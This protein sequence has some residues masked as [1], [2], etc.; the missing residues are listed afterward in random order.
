[1]KP[2]KSFV[3]D[4]ENLTLSYRNGSRV[5]NVYE[6]FDLKIQ[7]SEKVAL[8]GE[9]G[10]GKSTLARF[11]CG[12]LPKTA[13]IRDGRYLLEER[14][15]YAEH[16]FFHVNSVRGS[17]IAFI[18]QDAAESLNPVR[19]ILEQFTEL[20]LYHRICTKSEVETIAVKKLESLRIADIPR[21]LHAYPFELSGGMCQRVC[22]AMCL[23][24]NPVLLI[25][26]E[27]TSALDIRSTLRVLENISDLKNVAVLTITH[28]ISVAAKV[29]DRIIVLERGRISEEGTVSEILEYPKEAYTRELVAA[30]RN[31][32][33]LKALSEAK[34]TPI[35]SVQSVRKKYGGEEVLKD[36]SFEMYEEEV[37]GIIGESGCGKSTLCRC[38]MGL[39]DQVE[40][41]ILY[42]NK[43]LLEMKRKERRKLSTEIQMIFQNSRA[44]LNPGKSVRNL[45]MEPLKYNRLYDERERRR[46]AEE[47]LDAVEIPVKDREARPSELSTGQC[48]RVS[49]ARALSVNPKILVADEA[50]SALDVMIQYQVLELL[51]T[52][53]KDFH[54]TVLMI[55]H[56]IRLLRNY[57]DRI[58]IMQEGRFLEILLW[59]SGEG[60]K[61]E[62]TKFL[63]EVADHLTF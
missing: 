22:I 37:F 18:F 61:E 11:L 28:D 12:L 34:E 9:S 48:Q 60:A 5:T 26:D 54:L 44:V 29:A 50:V 58:G 7:T 2:S 33:M 27:P 49:I 20:L 63:L 3:V 39:E 35:L 56:D 42:G 6:N 15:I 32:P 59:D 53:K 13:K 17:K 25:A 52:L 10:S 41:R 31:I 38:I 47:L 46:I 23:C 51:Q 45:V 8:L 43:N 14:E 16:R 21:V 62:Y 24:L 30:Y 36:I 55:S 1:M 57:C 19:T 4:I 40:G